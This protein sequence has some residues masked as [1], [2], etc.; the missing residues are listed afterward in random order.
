MPEYDDEDQAMTPALQDETPA[1]SASSAE[2]SEQSEPTEQTIATGSPGDSAV[3]ASDFLPPWHVKG[4]DWNVGPTFNPSTDDTHDNPT[5]EDRTRRK[6]EDDPR[7]NGAQAPVEWWK[8][9]PLDLTP[10]DNPFTPEAQ[11]KQRQKDLAEAQQRA[12][13]RR[14]EEAD[15]KQRIEDMKKLSGPDERGD[16]PLPQ[17]DQRNG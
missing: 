13:K 14:Q 1:P 8:P 11:E 2:P 15:R 6:Q 3:A 17:T 12:E 4:T 5:N 7:G 9:K 16:Y 10:P